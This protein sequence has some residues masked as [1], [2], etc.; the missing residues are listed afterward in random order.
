VL[1]YLEGQTLA[2]RLASGPLAPAAALRHAIEICGALD[3]AHRSGI[4]HRDLKPA[5]VMIDIDV[6]PSRWLFSGESAHGAE[7]TFLA[8]DS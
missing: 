3:K 8:A 5:N 7:E 6:E 2:A 4:V 1:E